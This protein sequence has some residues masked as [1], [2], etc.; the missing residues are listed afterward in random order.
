MTALSPLTGVSLPVSTALFCD[1]RPR[2]FSHDFREL[3]RLRILK[4]PHSIAQYF[5]RYAVRERHY[6]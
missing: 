4:S 5:C 3:L 6:S 2:P 1:F